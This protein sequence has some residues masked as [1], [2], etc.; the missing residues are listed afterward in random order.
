MSSLAE[1]CTGKRCRGEESLGDA[2]GG[3][4]DINTYN[5][6]IFGFDRIFLLQTIDKIK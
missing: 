6:G 4:V 5:W 1:H 2:G 3:Y